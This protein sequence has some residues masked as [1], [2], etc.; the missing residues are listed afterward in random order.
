MRNIDLSTQNLEFG[1]GRARL[2]KQAGNSRIAGALIA[3]L[4][5]VLMAVPVMAQHAMTGRQNSEPD[6]RLFRP[7][8]CTW[9]SRF[10][11]DEG[12]FAAVRFGTSADIPVPA[13]YDGD[14]EI[15]IA[16]INQETGA[17]KIEFSGN[18]P[19]I[20][21]GFE[22]LLTFRQGDVPVPAD[23]DGDGKADIALW[24]PETGAWH[25][26]YS[27]ANPKGETTGQTWGA[28][29]DV[30]VPADYDGDGKTDFAVFRS[31]ENSWD[32]LNSG[33][34][35]IQVRYFGIAG[36]DTLVPA[37][38]T[39]DGR[40]DPAVFRDGNWYV[41]KSEN[42]E[43]E[44]FNLG[45]PDAIPVPADYDGDGE[46]DF[47]VFRRGMWYIVESSGTQFIARN[48][49]LDGDIPINSLRGRPSVIGVP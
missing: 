42:G 34:G 47:A 11:L 45:M 19:G 31:A 37:D 7:S 21:A 2:I 20:S 27:S 6:L 15:D 10:G 36:L 13:D 1:F 3:L 14:G 33:D 16:V 44:R 49:G 8:N 41:L 39:G 40:A 38:Y 25:I 28:R 46:A 32:I 17:W 22:K 5:A 23:Y 35:R 26:V 24:R 43:I 4:A 48:F 9:Y 12:A 29:G 30:P 18:R